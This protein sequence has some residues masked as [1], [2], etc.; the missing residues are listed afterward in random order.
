MARSVT[1]IYNEMI[2]EKVSS[3]ELDELNTVS[4]VAIYKAIFWVV[5]FAIHI[6]EALFDQLRTEVD[7]IVQKNRIGTPDWYINLALDFQIGYDL[8]VSPLNELTYLVDDE[9]ARIVARA[10]FEESNGELTIKVAK[11]TN[12]VLGPLTA[13]ELAQFS[14][15][16][17]RVKLVGTIVNTISLAPDE[18]ETEFNIYYNPIYSEAEVLERVNAQITDFVNNFNFGGVLYRSAF[19][20]SMLA[21]EG[22]ED[23]EITYIQPLNGADFGRKYSTA[24]GYF[25]FDD[26]AIAFI[27]I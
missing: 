1:T 15:Y 21:V 4:N 12:N 10:A 7:A 5:A 19:I 25:R 24:S 8:I 23:I 2:A 3:G 22:V 9:D 27:S 18:L 16:I 11:L 20:D 6:H 17:E 26:L 13:D 14:A